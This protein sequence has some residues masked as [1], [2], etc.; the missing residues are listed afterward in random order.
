MEVGLVDLFTWTRKFTIFQTLVCVL[1]HVS[2]GN[3][4]F[5]NFSFT[6]VHLMEEWEE[7]LRILVLFLS[8]SITKCHNCFIKQISCF[9]E[10]TCTNDEYLA[11]Q[12]LLKSIFK[13]AFHWHR[14]YPIGCQFPAN[15]LHLI[16][17]CGMGQSL[18]RQQPN[19]GPTLQALKY[20]TFLLV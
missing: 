6:F 7:I 10:T 4:E 5:F 2:D 9:W 1:D 16:T 8:K 15:N 11:L 13:F 3:D 19:K 14:L 12:L 18:D 20:D 17:Y